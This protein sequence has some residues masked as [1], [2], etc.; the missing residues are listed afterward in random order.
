LPKPDDPLGDLGQE[1]RLRARPL[2]LERRAHEQ[3]RH[4]RHRVRD[5]IEDERHQV[6]DSEEKATQ[7]LPGEVSALV[8]AWFCASAVGS[9]PFGAT[10]GS[11]ASSES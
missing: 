11:A 5:G 3:Q 7:R 6:T 1:V 9:C 10:W 4:Q 2:I 8:L